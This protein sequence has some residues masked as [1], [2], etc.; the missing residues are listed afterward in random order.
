MAPDIDWGKN[1][2]LMLDIGCTDAS[3]GVS[4]FEKDV[5]TMTLQLNDDLVDLG[6][7]AL[8]RGVLAVI[9]ALAT[10]RLPFPSGVFDAVHCGSCSVH[11]HSNGW[12]LTH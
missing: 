12:H 6:Q 11:W 2:R 7:V 10:K 9:S 1:I 8:E 5:L 4:L 3:F